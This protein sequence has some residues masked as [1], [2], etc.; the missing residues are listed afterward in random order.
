MGGLRWCIAVP[1]TS[2]GLICNR[3]RQH[4]FRVYYIYHTTYFFSIFM[5]KR[6]S[7]STLNLRI[8]DNIVRKTSTSFFV[9][10]KLSVG[11][12]V[13]GGRILFLSSFLHSVHRSLGIR[14]KEER[15]D[16]DEQS[17]GK[18]GRFNILTRIID[19]PLFI[20]SYI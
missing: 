2:L 18:V 19:S 6:G 15:G 5:Q 20:L 9:S 3:P 10:F 17:P 12:W 8:Y 13:V 14:S 1:F 16:G 4:R 11:R 7:G